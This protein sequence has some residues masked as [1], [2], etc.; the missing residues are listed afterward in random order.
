MDPDLTGAVGKMLL[1][2]FLDV[3]QRPSRNIALR[4][5]QQADSLQQKRI[6]VMMVQAAQMEETVLKTWVKES[7]VPLPVGIIRGEEDETRAAWGIRALPWLI[8]AGRD[9]VVRAEGFGL[10]ELQNRIEILA[11]E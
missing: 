9:H 3:Q 7:Q 2:C 10:E 8:L 1:I 5:A 4:V 11:K 6:M